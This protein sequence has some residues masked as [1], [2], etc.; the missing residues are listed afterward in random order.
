MS[1]E[2][3]PLAKTEAEK[4]KTFKL[5]FGL[6][7]LTN[8]KL[9]VF[10][11]QQIQNIKGRDN[12]AQIRAFFEQVGHGSCVC[13]IQDHEIFIVALRT[14]GPLYMQGLPRQIVARI[15]LA[16]IRGALRSSYVWI[17]DNNDP[18]ENVVVQWIPAKKSV[19]VF[20]S[21]EARSFLEDNEQS[22][23]LETPI[24]TFKNILKVLV[25]EA[26]K[27][28]L[29][30]DSG[31]WGFP[32]GAAVLLQTKGLDYVFVGDGRM[33]KFRAL[34]EITKFAA[35][36]GNND[37]TMAWA[38]DRKGHFYDFDDGFNVYKMQGDLTSAA[39]PG[40][41]IFGSKYGWGPDVESKYKLVQPQ[42]KPQDLTA[43][44]D[45]V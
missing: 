14:N 44:A 1:S 34:A 42:P 32:D 4:L 45:V 18:S 26:F 25:G 40:F 6:V 20:G 33:F 19:R 28:G 3:R 9:A 43:S 16:L 23:D 17:T 8:D 13:F 11:D 37:V 27:N 10:G 31:A 35:P 39:D 22:F 2:W 24:K 36:V 7:S 38:I 5:R 41:E 30:R 12:K 15:M 29:T 21:D